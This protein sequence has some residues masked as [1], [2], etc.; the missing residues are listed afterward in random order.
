MVYSSGFDDVAETVNRS[1]EE[2][3][4][5]QFESLNS[6]FQKNEKYH[7]MKLSFLVIF[8]IITIQSN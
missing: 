7:C 6:V 8:R 5:I 2:D 3:I 1:S 4:F